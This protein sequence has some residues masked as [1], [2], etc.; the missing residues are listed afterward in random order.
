MKSLISSLLITLATA[1]ILPRDDNHGWD[2]PRDAD[3]TP[4]FQRVAIFS[5]DSLHASD[6]PKWLAKGASNI[7]QMLKNGYLYSDAWTSFPSDS[8]PGTIAQYTGMQI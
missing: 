2:G 6:I 4:Q 1:A 7:S 8:F 5:I 3:G